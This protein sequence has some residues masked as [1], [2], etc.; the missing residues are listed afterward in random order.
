MPVAQ[1]IGAGRI[2]RRLR[3]L[4]L[5]WTGSPQQAHGCTQALGAV[6]AFAA[7]TAETVLLSHVDC[8]A[9]ASEP[10]SASISQQGIVFSSCRDLHIVRSAT[11][12][13]H[14]F[15]GFAHPSLGCVG[16]PACVSAESFPSLQCVHT[17]LSLVSGAPH[18]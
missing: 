11:L 3:P 6:L 13:A 10:L 2:A 18:R 14:P 17:S 4:A 9:E 1:Q 16:P 7:G 5:P 8:D 12:R 15:L